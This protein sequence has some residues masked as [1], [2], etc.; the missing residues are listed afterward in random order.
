MIPVTDLPGIYAMAAKPQPAPVPKPAA[1]PPPAGLG[2]VRQ[3]D[4][5]L[6]DFSGRLA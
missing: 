4:H 6:G 2:V 1:P 3:G 5:R